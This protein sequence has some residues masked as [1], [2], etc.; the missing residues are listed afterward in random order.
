MTDGEQRRYTL[1]FAVATV[2]PDL[3]GLLTGGAVGTPP[4]PSFS[5]DVAYPIKRT[6]WQWLTRRPRQYR[7]VVIHNARLDVVT[8]EECP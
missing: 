4:P 8:S 7:R 3:L 6:F 2:D 1:E 5:L